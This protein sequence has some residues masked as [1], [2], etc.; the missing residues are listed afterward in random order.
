MNSSETKDAEHWAERTVPQKE[1]IFVIRALPSASLHSPISGVRMNGTARYNGVAQSRST[2]LEKEQLGEAGYEHL[3]AAKSKHGNA[4]AALANVDIQEHRLPFAKLNMA[5]QTSV[6][7]K[8]PAQS[9]GLSSQ[10]AKFRLQLD[11]PN[12]LTPPKKKSTFRKVQAIF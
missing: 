10:E 2:T 3:E 5:F 1:E 9:F 4:S 8:E 7:T 11:G 12:I 6:N